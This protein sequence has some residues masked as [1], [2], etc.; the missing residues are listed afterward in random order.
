[1][2]IFIG[3]KEIKKKRRKGL[4]EIKKKKTGYVNFM[5]QNKHFII[6]FALVHILTLNMD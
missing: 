3:M 2:G 4:K 1:M 6:V 5:L